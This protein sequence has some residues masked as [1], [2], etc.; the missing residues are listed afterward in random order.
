MNMKNLY[1]LLIAITATMVAC[2]I[3]EAGGGGG[4]GGAKKDA[5]IKVRNRAGATGAVIID[6]G[7][8]PLTT[9]QELINAG[10]KKVENNGSPATFEVT[11]GAH[12]VRV[13]IVTAAGGLG[14]SRVDIVSPLKGKTK[15]AT[16]NAFAAPVVTDE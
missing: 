16:Y 2:G 12:N 14:A 9:L 6:Y 13:F 7:G 3:A 10:G 1:T 15:V 11:A 4:G 8:P 5:K